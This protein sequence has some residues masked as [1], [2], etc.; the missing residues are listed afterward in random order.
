MP[1]RQQGIAL[2]PTGRTVPPRRWGGTQ[3]LLV[4]S[5]RDHQMQKRYLWL[6]AG[7]L[8]FA[9]LLERDL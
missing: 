3:T 7:A 4:N 1:G 8:A 9:R 5:R 2:V 6:M